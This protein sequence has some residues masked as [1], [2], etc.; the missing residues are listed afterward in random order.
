MRMIDLSADRPAGR[1]AWLALACV[2]GF[3]LL[4]V[5]VNEQGA[6]PFDDPLTALVKGLPI[7]TDVWLVLTEAGGRILIPIGIAVVLVLIALR[8]RRDALIYGIALIGASVWTQV[9]KVAIA[10]Q[11]PADALVVASGFSF[12]SGHT[13]NSTV[14]YGLIAL[15]VWRSGR[16][17]WLRGASVVGLVVLIILVGLSRIALGAHFPSDVVGGWLAGV[18]IVA[19]VATLTADER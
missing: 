1:W 8:R 3:A 15:L 17:A 16:P 12:P 4:A 2:V 9:V 14:T 6:I 13:L 5:A 18:A 10:R 7:P 19:T 11:R